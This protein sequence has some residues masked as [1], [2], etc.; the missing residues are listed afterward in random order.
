[1][2]GTSAQPAERSLGSAVWRGSHMN[3]TKNGDTGIVLQE[4]RTRILNGFLAIAVIMSAPAFVAT[5]FSAISAP[6]LWPVAIAF[7]VVELILIVLV[8]LRGLNYLIRV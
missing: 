1:M 2:V 5:F 4:W 3:V 7:L 6:G 8:V